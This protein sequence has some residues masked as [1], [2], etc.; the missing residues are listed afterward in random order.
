MDQLNVDIGTFTKAKTM[1]EQH[2]P[3]QFG[4]TTLATKAKVHIKR[5]DYVLAA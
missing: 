2:T 4:Y 3:L 1:D 5:S